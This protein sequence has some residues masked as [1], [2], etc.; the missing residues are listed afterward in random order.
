MNTYPL[1]TIGSA[2]PF[3]IQYGLQTMLNHQLKKTP[4]LV[5]GRFQLCLL[6][7][8]FVSLAFLFPLP[9][10]PHQVVRQIF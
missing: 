2:E 8:I 9:C 3:S 7:P 4:D 10:T 5:I 6:N 1:F